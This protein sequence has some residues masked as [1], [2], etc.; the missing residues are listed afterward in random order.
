ML[1]VWIDSLLAKKTCF[2]GCQREVE[3]ENAVTAARDRALQS[4]YH[5][6]KILGTETD[7]KCRISKQFDETV[8]NITST[9]PICTKNDT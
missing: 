1:A 2:Y 6:T 8:E 5:G 3:T 4:K 9:C 7:S